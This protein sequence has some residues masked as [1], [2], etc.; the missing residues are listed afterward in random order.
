MTDVL[1][2]GRGLAATTLMHILHEHRVEFKVVGD[3]NLSHCSKVAAGIWNPVVFK[4]LTKSWLADDLVPELL[5]FYKD[6]EKRLGQKLITDRSLLKPFTEDQEK[7][8]WQKRAGEELKDFL[9][10]VLLSPTSP[11]LKHYRIPNQYGVVKNCGNLDV[12]KFLTAT[13]LLFKE[14]IF[15]EVFDHSKLEILEN[16]IRY[17]DLNAKHIIFCEG[18]LVK[19]NPFFSWIPL[20][21]AKGEILSVTSSHLTLKNAV[22]NRNGFLMDI[23]DNLYKAGATYNWDDLS[24]QLTPHGLAELQQKLSAMIDCSY[25]IIKHESGIR[26]SSADRRPIIGRHPQYERLFVMN[27]FGTK[28]VMLAPFFVKNFVNFYLQKEELHKDVNVNRFYHLY[29]QKKEN[30]INRP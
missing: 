10:P 14:R 12:A 6:S 2:V 27:G 25:T 1:I 8:L 28:G 5:R 26:P 7:T 16:G 19:Q 3:E 29:G 22:F 13:T 21:P 11:D 18:Y 4:R 24:E 20:K 15:P 9:D 17:K 23:G 30:E